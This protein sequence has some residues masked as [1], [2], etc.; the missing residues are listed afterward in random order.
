MDKCKLT[1]ITPQV[2]KGGPLFESGLFGVNAEITRKGIFGGLSAQMLNNRKLYMGN[3]D[4]DGWECINFQRV[5]DRSEESLCCSNFIILKNGGCMSQTSSVIALKSG[6]DYEAKVWVKAITDKVDITFGVKGSEHTV[7]VSADGEKYRELSFLFAGEDINNGTFLVKVIGEAA[8]FEAS[9][10][11]TDH[12]Y[13]MRRDVI[14]QLRYIS[15]TAIRFPGGCAADHFDWKESLKAP[16][17]RKP[18]DGR[19]KDW[20]LFRDT[21]HQDPLDIGLNEF[22]MLCRELNAEPE[23]TVSLILSDG[24]DAAKLTEYCNGSRDSEYGAIRES[25]GFEA[26]NIHLWYIGNEAYFFGGEYEDSK[27]AAERTDELITAMK[28]VDPSIAVAIGL[29]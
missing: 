4:V 29:T 14:E 12:Y 6:E 24:E 27:K 3:E 19:S 13:G 2:K 28:R 22:I 1:S 18:A 10:M 7:T 15:P 16:E 5:V 17:F 20:F 11:P 8:V 9:L 23:Y 21:Y 26:F 25:L